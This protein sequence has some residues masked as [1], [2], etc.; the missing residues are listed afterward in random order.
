LVGTAFIRNKNLINFPNKMPLYNFNCGALAKLAKHSKNAPT[1]NIS[2]AAQPKAFLW[3]RGLMNQKW[4]K[5]LI[6][7]RT[8]VIINRTKEME[9]APT[10]AFRTQQVLS[11]NKVKISGICLPPKPQRVVCACL[12]VFWV[13]LCELEWKEYKPQ[14]HVVD[15]KRWLETTRP[16]MNKTMGGMWWSFLF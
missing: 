16:P 9:S 5:M 1:W 10:K 8:D 7:F 13:Y 6:Y 14:E 15:G 3:F 4:G 11:G 2:F 12:Y